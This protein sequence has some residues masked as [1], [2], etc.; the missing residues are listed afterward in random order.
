MNI[1]NASNPDGIRTG[2]VKYIIH[3]GGGADDIE[4]FKSIRNKKYSYNVTFNVVESI[5]VEV[6]GGEDKEG[7][8]PGVEG[9]V[10]DAKTIVYSLD[11][12]YNCIN[13]GFTYEEIKELSF[14]IQSPFADDAIYSE[15]NKLPGTE[16]E[17][18]DYKW[19]KLQRTTDAQTLA[20]YREKGTTP[21][22]LYDL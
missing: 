7:A 17:A 22:Y 15:T 5:I 10:V 8:N 21:I 11:A 12:H 1:K 3:L 19:I 13:L 18:G 14:I 2:E 9:D 6:Q 4:N 20:K 16:K